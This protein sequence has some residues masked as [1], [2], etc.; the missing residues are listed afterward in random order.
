MFEGYDIVRG[1][2]LQDCEMSV[3]WHGC[4]S[5]PRKIKGGGPQGA[6]LGLLEYLSQSNNNADCVSESE[7]FKFLDDLSILEI[8]NLL[9]IGISSFNVKNQV[10]NGIPA[11]NQY[12][13]PEKLQSQDSLNQSND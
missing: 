12:I 7:R 5:V 4:Q 10:P 8:I 2:D 9:T 11:R 1:D 13:S 6:T 3:K